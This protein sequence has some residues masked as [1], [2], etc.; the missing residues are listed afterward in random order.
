MGKLLTF[1]YWVELR[2]GYK[3][4]QIDAEIENEFSFIIKAPN[5]A[6]ADRMIK[7]MFSN[8]NVVTYD[9]VCID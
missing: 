6:T 9:G 7:A 4:A 8:D 2:N 3:P 1:E 5:R